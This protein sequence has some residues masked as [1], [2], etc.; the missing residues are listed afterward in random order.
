MARITIDRLTAEHHPAHAVARAQGESPSF[1]N[2]LGGLA[3]AVLLSAEAIRTPT[4]G[5]SPSPSSGAGVFLAPSRHHKRQGLSRSSASAAAPIPEEE[6][7]GLRTARTAVSEAVSAVFGREQALAVCDIFFEAPFSTTN[8]DEFQRAFMRGLHKLGM[9]DAELERLTCSL[10][11]SPLIARL[12][13]P[14]AIVEKMSRL[15]LHK[16]KVLGYHAYLSMEDVDRRSSSNSRSRSRS[17]RASRSVTALSIHRIPRPG[18]TEQDDLAAQILQDPAGP[19]AGAEHLD[20]GAS[21]ATLPSSRTDDSIGRD[22]LERLSA[23]GTQR[24]PT[25]DEIRSIAK[26][27]AQTHHLSKD[28]LH[29]VIDT[30]REI[31]TTLFGLPGAAPHGVAMA[32]Q[33]LHRIAQ[34]V[35]DNRAP[36]DE[37][38]Q[39]TLKMM[40]DSLFGVQSAEEVAAHSSH[41]RTRSGPR[42]EASEMLRTARSSIISH[43][44][45]STSA[46][47]ALTSAPSVPSAHTGSTA[48]VV[49]KAEME[50]EVL[51]MVEDLYDIVFTSQY[52]Y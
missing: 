8:R 25:E 11:P 47:S 15:P 7:A 34:H 16:L 35:T 50:N 33:D 46:H 10:R 9:K 42:S 52:P 44:R 2:A 45:P 20:D 30:L 29:K 19:I 32:P 26:Q 1:S 5:V 31:S 41:S 12:S 37:A 38:A 39:S 4:Q 14:P 36:D 27:V 22:L 49:V 24:R 43:S 18:E 13:G 40:T 48:S 3:K 51:G 17:S 21:S 6:I 28:R 23:R